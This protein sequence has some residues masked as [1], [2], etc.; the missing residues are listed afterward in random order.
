MAHRG[1][2][3][4]RIRA[5]RRQT[6][7]LFGA[8][9]D[10]TLSGSPSAVITT[11]LNAAA[12]ALRP[13]TIVRTRGIM[14]V[15]SD[16]NAADESYIGDMALAVVSDQAVA[17]GVTAVPTPLTDKGSD[18][19]FVYE[20]IPGRIEVFDTTGVLEP[21]GQFIQWDS[22]AMRKVNDDQDVVSVVENEI[23]GV[24]MITSC[25]MLIKLH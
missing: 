13:F 18:L 23:A 9:V 15:M 8:T 4:E 24:R 16:Q 12:L 21:R 22:K 5:Q 3:R 10:T 2:T 14:H 6:L 11:S 19:F 1:F 17:V 20:Q 25:R 7:W